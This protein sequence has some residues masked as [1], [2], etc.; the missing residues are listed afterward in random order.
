MTYVTRR[1]FLHRMAAGLG[2]LGMK[3]LM[4]VIRDRPAMHRNLG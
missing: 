1:D 2:A 4:G 3:N